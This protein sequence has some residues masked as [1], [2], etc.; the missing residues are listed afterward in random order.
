[1]GLLYKCMLAGMGV[2]L[3][4]SLV[5]AYL[6][7]VIGAPLTPYRQLYSHLQPPAQASTESPKR[8]L[9]LGTSLTHAGSW[10]D[11]LRQALQGCAGEAVQVVKLAVPGNVS[12]RGLAMLRDYLAE[13]PPID[14]LFVEFSINDASLYRGTPLYLSRRNHEAILGLVNRQRTQVVLSTMNPAWGRNARERPGLARYQALY[15]ELA[16]VYGL[17][18]IDT[19]VLWRRLTPAQRAQWLP[20]GL[21]PTPAGMRAVALPALIEG[22][23]PLLCGP[24]LGPKMAQ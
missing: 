2:A 22:L 1:M 24:G 12:R 13:G 21:H 17:G 18:L 3:L 8:I 15:R 9:F 19:S 14:L 23:R 4:A 6:Y 11:E 10:V 16:Q 7:G 5:G 20:D